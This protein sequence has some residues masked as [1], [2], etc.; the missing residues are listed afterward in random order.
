VF[1][2]KVT[3]ARD[4]ASA[5]C[6]ANILGAAIGALAGSILGV[7]W[8]SL[9]AATLVVVLLCYAM[10]LDSAVKSACA[11]VAIVMFTQTGNV[12]TAGAERVIAVVIGCASALIAILVF[13]SL[14]NVTT[15]LLSRRQPA[16][17]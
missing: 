3:D 17:K 1:Q 8:I 15:K 7:N 4:L 9:G 11:C 13:T 6:A 2:P 5:R 14:A 16:P 12:K 10:H